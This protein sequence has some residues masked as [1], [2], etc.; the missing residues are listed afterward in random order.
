MTR[1]ELMRFMEE[2]MDTMRKIAKA[3]NADYTGSTDDPF[4]N[5]TVVEQRGIATTEQGFLTRMSDK[6]ERITSFVRK[7][8]LAVK[9]ESVSDTLMDLANYCLLFMAYIK[10]KS[11]KK[12]QMRPI[13]VTWSEWPSV[14]PTKAIDHTGAVWYGTVDMDNSRKPMDIDYSKEE[15]EDD[16]V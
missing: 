15:I 4:A 11:N 3:K 1:E 9:D 12:A 6:M 5:F 7:G 14:L 16:K 13:K 2:T 8:E 10:D